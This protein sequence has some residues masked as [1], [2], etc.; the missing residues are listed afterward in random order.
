M[1]KANEVISLPVLDLESG[2][3]R[4]NVRDVLFCD[5]WT[6]QGLLVEVKALFRKNRFVP[7]HKV[8][9]F[10]EDFVVIKNEQGLQPAQDAEGYN[11]IRTGPVVVIG[12][13]AISSDGQFL[14]QIEDVYFQTEFGEIVGYE[15]SDGI[16]SDIVE[17]RKTVS[18]VENAKISDDAVILP[19]TQI[20]QEEI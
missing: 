1:L 9:A 4:G 7:L 19:S 10:G 18:H 6:F 14:G 3:E 2:Q 12:K 20:E 5:D 17:G 13:P 15:L 11:G 16:F 8:H